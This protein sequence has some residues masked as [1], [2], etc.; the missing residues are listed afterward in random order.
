MSEPKTGKGN[1]GESEDKANKATGSEDRTAA[2]ERELR[3]MIE[4]VEKKQGD[5]VH[6][7]EESPHDFVE[8]RRREK[9]KEDSSKDGSSKE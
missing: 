1:A 2:R 4:R 9:S 7:G 8:R 3:E 5:S 6:P